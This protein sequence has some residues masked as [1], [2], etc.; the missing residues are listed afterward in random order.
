MAFMLYNL[1]AISASMP[2]L[3]LGKKT[4]IYYERILYNRYPDL[5]RNNHVLIYL[6]TNKLRPKEK[7]ILIL[8]NYIAPL[9]PMLLVFSYF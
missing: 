2:G 8:T 6:W 4:Q 7:V 5:K 1:L 9:L 3:Y